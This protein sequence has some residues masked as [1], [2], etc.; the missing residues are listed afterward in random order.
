M[1]KNN[2]VISFFEFLYINIINSLIFKYQMI[3]KLNFLKNMHTFYLDL[4]IEC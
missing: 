4:D 1:L 2:N 3:N